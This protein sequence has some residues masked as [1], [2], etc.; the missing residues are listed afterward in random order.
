M[1]YK[2]IGIEFCFPERTLHEKVGG[3]THSLFRVHSIRAD[4]SEAKDRLSLKLDVSNFKG[5]NGTCNSFD[6][7]MDDYSS[8]LNS[9]TLG[10]HLTLPRK[11][12]Y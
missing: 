5:Q 11:Y 4:S 6:S 1:T 10:L 8:F 3:I 2:D 7:T 12:I 9:V